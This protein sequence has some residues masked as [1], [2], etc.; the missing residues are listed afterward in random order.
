[1][2]KGVYTAIIT[3]FHDGRVDGK[4]LEE[5]VS[6]QVE[7]GVQGIVPCG[8]TGESLLLSPEEQKY[9]IDVCKSV[10]GDSIQVIPGTGR[11]TTSET[12]ELSRQAE[13]THVDGVLIMTPWY[14]RP[15]QESLVH[16]Y[17]QI[18]QA[19]GIPF[20]L[21]NN[22]V[23]TGVNITFESL[24][25]LNECRNFRGYKESGSDFAQIAKLKDYYQDRLRVFAG[26][27]DVLAAHLGM[28]ADGGILSAANAI[29]QY[30]VG[31][32]KAW[33]DGNL[34]LF[35]K[36]WAELF[37]LL[38]ALSQECNPLPSRYMMELLYGVSPEMRLPF[39]PL[40]D[41][42][43]RDIETALQNLGLWEPLASVR[44]R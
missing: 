8:T 30:F 1:M 41:S 43:K 15:S 11:L 36:R 24:K 40:K 39:L 32:V 23:R 6:R 9:I 13:K 33:E 37:P 5:L 14:L 21:Y 22:P 27:D 42:T 29:P 20:I 28:G 4:K 25:M 26:N 35:K 12:I 2:F 19:I 17:Q 18:D 38:S 3:P 10:C 16:Y 44:E 7:A 31:I 34:S